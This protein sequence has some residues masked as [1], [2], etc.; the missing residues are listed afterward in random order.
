MNRVVTVL[1][2]G[3]I[4]LGAAEANAQMLQ[5]TDRAFLNVSGGVQ[6]G[7]KDVATNLSFPLY[8]ETATVDTT[9]EV[10]G[11]AIWD[12]TGG[13]R[14]WS[15]L[16]AVLSVSGRS[17]NSDGSS[18]AAIP[19]PA[20]YEQFRTVSASLPDMKHSERWAGIMAGWMMPVSDKFEVMAMFGPAVASVKH[21]LVSGASVVEGTT[22]TV[23]LT[24]TTA[25]KSVWGVMGV[26]DGR[27]MLN[28]RFGVGG[29]LRYQSATA[30][31]ATATKMKVGGFQLGV[32]VRVRY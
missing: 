21:A 26:V 28:E 15:N 25:S 19:N 27:Y 24:V 18:V 17:A 1:S 9:R 29:F 8:D 31:L 23:N 14:V 3:A 13:V 30:N 16:A 7:K 22:P 10:K 12:I 5:W 20:F 2:A 11:S 4:L 6:T 32:G